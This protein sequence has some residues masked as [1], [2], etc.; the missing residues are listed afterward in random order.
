[1]PFVVLGDPTY[2]QSLNIIGSL[3][4]S[5]AGALELGFPFSD[6][7]ADGP[8]IQKANKRAL[9]NHMTTKK[10]FDILAQVRSYSDIPISLMLSYNIVYNYGTEEFYKRCNRLEIDAILCPDVPLEESGPLLKYS[11][12]YKIPQVFLVSP[13]TTGPRMKQLATISN[14]TS[15]YVYLVSLLG[16]TG[17]RQ[18]TNTELPAL[19]KQT[20][21]YFNI[22]VYV[23]F[24]ISSPEHVKDVLSLGADGAISGSAI[25]KIIEEN[26][27]NQEL[28]QKKAVD[29]VKK[30]KV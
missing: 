14:Q 1:M 23:G 2:S 13:T 21:R 8:V 19:I 4:K 3:I 17:V 20:K 28:L 18:D 9:D 26:L 5:G 16:T 15:G 10:C 12:K 24:G 27:D 11:K 7:I 29:F 25:C 6:P 30:M 22:P